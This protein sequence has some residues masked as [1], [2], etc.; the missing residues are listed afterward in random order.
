MRDKET[1]VSHRQHYKTVALVFFITAII[2]IL[3][4]TGLTA[5]GASWQSGGL[6]IVVGPFAGLGFGF[7]YLRRYLQS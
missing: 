4:Q 3:I 2:L 5:L 7:Y 1:S 6:L